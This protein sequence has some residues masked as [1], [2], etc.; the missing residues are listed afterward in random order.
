MRPNPIFFVVVSGLVMSV[1]QWYGATY[2]PQGAYIRGTI[3]TEWA[4]GRGVVYE[5]LGKV[6]HLHRGNKN[7]SL[8]QRNQ[9]FLILQ[10]AHVETL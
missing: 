8:K 6:I 1:W 2:L 5:N 3:W 10:T 7:R 9:V 4:S